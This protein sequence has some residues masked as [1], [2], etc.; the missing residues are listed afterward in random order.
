MASQKELKDG[1]VDE[2]IKKIET[3]PNLTWNQMVNVEFPRNLDGRFYNGANIINL[4]LSTIG[5]DYSSNIWGTFKD[6]EKAGGKILKGEKSTSV[7]FFKMIDEK[8]KITGE[9]T[10]MR[11]PL[12]R[13]YKVFNIGQTT[14]QEKDLK[15]EPVRKENPEKVIEGYSKNSGV[16]IKTSLE[17][18]AYYSPSLDYIVTPPIENYKNIDKYYST[19]FHEITHSTGNEKRLNRDMGKIFGN[20]KYAKEELVAEL[21]AAFLMNTCG[22]KNDDIEKN[23]AAYLKSWLGVLKNDKNLLYD[24]AKYSQKAHDY[25]IEISEVKLEKEIVKDEKEINNIIKEIEKEKIIKSIEFEKENKEN[26]II[27]EEKENIVGKDSKGQEYR[28]ENITDVRVTMSKSGYIA[29]KSETICSLKKEYDFN[30]LKHEDKE[31]GVMTK[32]IIDKEKKEAKIVREFDE[33]FNKRM[34]EKTIEQ[35]MKKGKDMEIDK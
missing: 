16:E 11:I 18:T 14:L 5:K 31:K 29:V 24:A 33:K 32:V 1:I 17:G 9:E 27:I 8:D 25:V 30:E 15:L 23:N 22:I 10:G 28:F 3:T 12:F 21:G 7:L 19:V 26:R 35:E 2:I 34:L 13:E 6:I 20:E 4:N